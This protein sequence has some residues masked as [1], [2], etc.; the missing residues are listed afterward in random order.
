MT[1]AENTAIIHPLNKKENGVIT[2][3]NTKLLINKP[4]PD[5]LEQKATQLLCGAIPL[6]A[7]VSD[8][9]LISKYGNSVIL[10]CAD[11]LIAVDK[12]L[13][14]GGTM[15]L[16]EDIAEAKVKRL[17]GNAVFKAEMKDGKTLD[18]IYRK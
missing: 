5:D 3:E 4:L 1:T 9:N 13:P 17:Y 8:L 11:R 16:F 18:E 12:Y 14:D 10:I 2:T 7:V 15:L 6:M